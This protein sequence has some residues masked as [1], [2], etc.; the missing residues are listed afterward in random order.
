MSGATPPDLIAAPHLF[1]FF[2]DEIFK[3]L[4]RRTRRALC[5]VALYDVQGRRLALQGIRPDAAERIVQTGIN[6]WLFTESDERLDMHPLLRTFL[7]RKLET[8][9][10][11]RAESRRWAS[12]GESHWPRLVGRSIR[13]IQRFDQR[14]LLPNL[15]EASMERLLATGRATTLRAWVAAAPQNASMVR[16]AGAELALREGRYYESETLAVLAARD[17]S[18]APD[19]AAR[20]NSWRAAQLTLPPA[21]RKQRPT[22]DRRRRSQ[23]R[24]SLFAGQSSENSKLQSSWSPAMC[25]SACKSSVPAKHLIRRG[26]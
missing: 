8:E 3:R 18:D 4:D 13:V 11:A 2:A 5:E 6:S 1:G 14:G 12:R 21:R 19:R 10:P 15:I 26:K 22:T 7:F 9:S 17:L 16:L 20:A 24:Q 25:R 23:D